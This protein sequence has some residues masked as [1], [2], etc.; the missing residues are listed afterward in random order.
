M[1]KYQNLSK[2]NSVIHLTQAGA[3]KL[4]EHTIAFILVAVFFSRLDL[5]SDFFVLPTQTQ[6][7]SKLS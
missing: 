7:S 2:K 1:R 3:L 6:L 5:L 4:H